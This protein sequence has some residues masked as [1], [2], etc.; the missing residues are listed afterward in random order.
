MTPAPCKSSVIFLL[1]HRYLLPTSFFVVYYK[2][3][4]SQ[5]LKEILELVQELKELIN[6]NLELISIVDT[7]LQKELETI[8]ESND[9][10]W[11][12]GYNIRQDIKALKIENEVA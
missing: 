6:S 4:D 7:E 12:K 3:K 10:G 2:K 9:D 11:A 8:D 1:H 5:N